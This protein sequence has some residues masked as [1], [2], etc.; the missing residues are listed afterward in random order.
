MEI[1]HTWQAPHHTFYLQSRVD[2]Y[3]TSVIILRCSGTHIAVRTDSLVM[4]DLDR[5]SVV[6]D[7]H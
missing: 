1:L 3:V 4:L 5:E 7:L 6:A 2:L